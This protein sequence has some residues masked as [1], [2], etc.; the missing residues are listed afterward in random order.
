MPLS[1]NE[2]RHRAIQFGHDWA[3]TRSEAAEK[4]TFWNEYLFS[5]YEQLT[6]PLLPPTASKPPRKRISA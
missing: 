4:Q 3:G 1:W 6:A 5:L 2:I